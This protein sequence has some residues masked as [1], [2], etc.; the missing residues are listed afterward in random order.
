ARGRSEEFVLPEPV[1][2]FS[3]LTRHYEK[4][5]R[6]PAAP[7]C[8]FPAS[9]S[10][11]LLG[12]L[13]ETLAH[14]VFSNQPVVPHG[15]PHGL[16]ASDRMDGDIHVRFQFHRLIVPYRGPL[17]EVIPLA[18]GEEPAFRPLSL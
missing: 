12:S 11:Y 8:C 6:I 4:L 7:R 1:C 14:A 2:C 10:E 13:V 18:V 3:A 15:H 9:H 17:D 16:R 5:A